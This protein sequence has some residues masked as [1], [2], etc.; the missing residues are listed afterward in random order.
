MRSHRVRVT[1]VVTVVSSFIVAC[2]FAFAYNYIQH[3]QRRSSFVQLDAALEAIRLDVK[4]DQPKD[5]LK[6]LHTSPHGLSA[7]V[8]DSSG[9]VIVA[10]GSIP[11]SAKSG[12][13]IANMNGVLVIYVSGREEGKTVVVAD[14]WTDVMLSNMRMMVL[15]VILWLT[16]TI[17]TA[18]VT[19]ISITRTFRPLLEMANEADRLSTQGLTSRLAVPE[20]QEFGQLASKL[21]S[22]LDRLEETV[23]LQE[24][25]LQDAAHELRTPLTILR[26]QAETALLRH[27]S[28]DEY[29]SVLKTLL[30][31]AVRMSRLVESLLVS[32]RASINEASE[33]ELAIPIQESVDTWQDRFNEAG[34]KLQSSIGLVRMKI[35]EQEISIVMDNL[36]GNALRHSPKG[37]TC[38][39]VLSQNKGECR[40]TISDQGS[41]ITDEHKKQI[42][43]RFF[44]T[45]ESRG[46]NTGGFGIG[47]AIC[48]RILNERS[49]TISVEDNWPKGSTF[50]IEWQRGQLNKPGS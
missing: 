46:R 39:V 45:D 49:A 3:E 43:Q 11:M 24:Q 44:R 8:F 2:L 32:S 16:L 38:H 22:F 15:L 36:L 37:T 35:S 19:W 31:E 25:F 47:L 21:N 13:G 50:V 42:F 9:Q 34:V 30:E 5:Y 28:S 14:T 7:A 4:Y 26:G 1:F 33:V 23:E 10:E 17:L 27:R 40:L 18:T 41:G 12:R 6:I 20:D 29:E 48:K